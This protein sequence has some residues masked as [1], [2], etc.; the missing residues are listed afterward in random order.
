MVS[1]S[2][3][4]IYQISQIVLLEHQNDVMTLEKRITSQILKKFAINSV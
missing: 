1:T 2:V 3:A 4:M